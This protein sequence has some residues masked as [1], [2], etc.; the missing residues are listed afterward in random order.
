MPDIELA[1]DTEKCYKVNIG[2]TDIYFKSSDI[3]HYKNQQFSGDSFYEM[4]ANQKLPI[5]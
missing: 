1:L 3:L 2:G 5:L 4:V